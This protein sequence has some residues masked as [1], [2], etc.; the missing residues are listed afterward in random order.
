M[1]LATGK[2][3]PSSVRLFEK[4]FSSTFST[5]NE[6][7]IKPIKGLI[8]KIFEECRGASCESRV[9]RPLGELII[10]DDGGGKFRV[11]SVQESKKVS[12]TH[13][14]PVMRL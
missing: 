9:Q 8:F 7:G 14:W 1:P 2:R 4:C 3:K 13:V 5:Q 6:V 12:V 10:N 11:T